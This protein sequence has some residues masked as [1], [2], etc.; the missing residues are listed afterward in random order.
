MDAIRTACLLVSVLLASLA[1][2]S[3]PDSVAA[4][5]PADL[6]VY[7]RVWTG[8][9]ARPWAQAFAG[10]GGPDA[11]P[12]ESIDRARVRTTVVGGKVVFQRS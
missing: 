5:R 4:T 8:D 2:H 9:S 12:P 7:G 3:L 1:C 11:I 10:A 6:M